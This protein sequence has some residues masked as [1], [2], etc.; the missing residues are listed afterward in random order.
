MAPAKVVKQESKVAEPEKKAVYR[1]LELAV[2]QKGLVVWQE[3]SDDK[4]FFVS[5]D[6][7]ILYEGID[8]HIQKSEQVKDFVAEVGDYVL[9]RSIDDDML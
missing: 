9:A 8:P 5:G 3:E 6:E 2:K 7:K 1:K 4:M